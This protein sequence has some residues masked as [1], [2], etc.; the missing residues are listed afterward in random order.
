MM[1]FLR[2]SESSST[3]PDDRLSVR[4]ALGADL[5]RT[6]PP[7]NAGPLLWRLE[8]LVK[9]LVQ[10]RVQALVLYRLAQPLARRGWHGLAHV[11]QGRMIRRT[12]A[13][14]S[15]MADIGPGLLIM[16]SVGI[17]IGPDVCAG[18]DLT[19][20][21]NVTLGDGSRPGQPTLGDSVTLGAGAAVLGPITIGDGARV[22]ANAVVTKD[23]PAQSVATGIPAEHRVLRSVEGTAPAA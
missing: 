10:P 19:L 16:H 11:L 8:V 15:P 20:Y 23:V 7:R 17:V 5:R 14:I 12:G 1:N 2:A 13:D 18:R 4:A 3:V 9:C 21:Q 22:G 6:I